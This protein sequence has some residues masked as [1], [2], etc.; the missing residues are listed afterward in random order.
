MEKL[1]E[2]LK[3]KLLDA[4]EVITFNL[5]RA[6]TAKNKVTSLSAKLALVEAEV[7]RLQGIVASS[8]AKVAKYQEEVSELRLNTHMMTL[9]GWKNTVLLKEKKTIEHGVHFDEFSSIKDEDK[10]GTSRNMDVEDM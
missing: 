3:T 7:L 9:G 6:L 4:N 2:D 1:A 5:E 8:E 10:A